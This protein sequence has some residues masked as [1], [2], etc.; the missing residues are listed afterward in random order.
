MSPLIEFSDLAKAYPGPAGPAVIVDG[1][2]LGVERGEFVCLIG[3]SGC[4]KST[5]LSIVMG[6]NEPSRGGVMLNGTEIDGPG[7]DRGVVFQT[8]CLFPWMSVQENVRLAVAQV[9]PNAS[10]KEQRA[11]ARE[12]LEALGLGE[13]ADRFPAELSAGMR[14][15]AGIARAFASEPKVLLLDEPFSLLDVL[16]RLDLQ[17]ELLRQWQGTQKTVLMV[18]HDVDEALYLADR[19]V[20]MTA[21]PAATIGDILTA[22]FPRPR[23][24]EDVLEHPQYY[25]LRDRLINFL[26]SQA[27]KSPAPPETP[28]ESLPNPYLAEDTGRV[29]VAPAITTE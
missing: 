10:R 7:T 6:L 12:H 5:V 19:I 9:K 8:P 25:A 17:D 3:H 26:E 24:R 21:G 22:P 20:M 23:R 27:H 29:L 4:G 2:N 16:T 18:T 1:F 13:A 11:L 28:P 15:R 14:Q